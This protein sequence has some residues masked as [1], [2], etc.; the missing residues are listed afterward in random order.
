MIWAI[1]VI[2]ESSLLIYFNNIICK[3]RYLLLVI[4][5]VSVITTSFTQT[6]Q[7]PIV[8]VI[9]II[10]VVI[11]I[12]DV[13]VIVVTIMKGVDIFNRILNNLIT[14]LIVIQI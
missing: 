13:I 12:A 14:S 10:I 6:A 1:T 7:N 11:I 9:I 3:V 5:W 2:S 8:V 4:V